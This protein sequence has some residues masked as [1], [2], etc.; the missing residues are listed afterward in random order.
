MLSAILS[1]KPANSTKVISLLVAAATRTLSPPP[2]SF[3]R[4]FAGAGKKGADNNTD[5]CM[6]R[7]I[8]SAGLA[9]CFSAFFPRAFPRAFAITSDACRARGRLRD[10]HILLALHRAAC[11]RDCF[12]R[13]LLNA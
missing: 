4:F 9:L 11:A 5:A 12:I 13:V 7:N 3:S 2:P 10:A 6:Q 8:H 1:S